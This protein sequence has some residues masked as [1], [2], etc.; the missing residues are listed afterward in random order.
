MHGVI[1]SNKRYRQIKY[2]KMKS[3][4]LGYLTCDVEMQLYKFKRVADQETRESSL[5]NMSIIA[6]QWIVKMQ[7]YEFKFNLFFKVFMF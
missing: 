6:A 5:N 4:V 1:Y 2:L 7:R 3:K